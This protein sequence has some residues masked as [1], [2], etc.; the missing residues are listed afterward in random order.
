M[1]LKTGKED[2]LGIQIDYDKEDKL[3][4]FSLATLKDRY[5][6]GDETHAQHAFAR[7][8][9]FG[10]TYQGVTDF[11]FAQRL[12]NYASDNWFM[13]STP[14]LSNGGLERGQPISCFLNYVPDSRGGL[15]DHHD[16]NIWLASAGG[17]IGGYWGDI[18][19][20]GVS[21]SNGSESTGS[22][23][24]M[25]VIDSQ[26]LAYNQGKTRRGS[27][28]AYMDISHP[29]IEEFIAMRKTTGGDL[30]RKCLNLHNGVNITD[31]F[32]QAVKQDQPWRLIDPKTKTAIKTLQARD[33][34]WQLIHT[35]AET[36]EPY[37]VNLDRCNEAMPRPQKDMGLKIRQSNLCSEITLP[38]D[39][40]RTAVCCLSSV[41]LEYFDEWKDDP[42]FVQDLIKMLDNILE[43]FISNTSNVADALEKP[44][45][46]Q[47]F[48]NYVRE[49]ETRD[50]QKEYNGKS[51]AA[52]SAYRE[53]AVGL[54]AM[55]F[56]SYLQRN[57]IPFEGM[58][59]A[60]FNNRCF[61]YIKEQAEQASKLLGESRGEA[62]DM[63]GTGLRNSCLLAVAPNASSSIICGGTSPSIEPIRANVFTHKTLT[64]SFKVK[65][66][67]LELLLD[68]RGI[69]NDKTW[70]SIAAN[71]GSVEHLDELTDEEKE[72]FKTA[73]DINQIWVV[74]HAYQRQN[75]IC[76]SQSVNLFFIPPP[77]TAD[78]EIHDEYLQYV[79][80]VHWTGANKLKSMYYLR[81]NA[82]RNT[83]NVNVKIPRINLEEQECLS[84]EG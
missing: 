16:E 64:G 24:F 79:H 4:E 57:S 10:A 82:A 3:T 63:V 15:S 53:R 78:Q 37:I 41:N 76:Q 71:E 19:S 66:K 13:F 75:Y 43:H 27:Y 69:N 45:T 5:L 83:E 40:E 11:N 70:Q 52:Y 51:K 9:V 60:S 35:R 7:A 77:A 18:R 29:E 81:S 68:Q 14:I 74:E 17:G 30:N 26:M 2:Y 21:T 48:M 31:E 8:S 55:G 28:A 49:G 22:I 38:T 36:G 73:P 61:K 56:H 23:P 33:L 20:N 80:N 54:G 59:A 6:Y 65:N 72:V 58:Y 42:F 32:L 1:I 62:P 12:Y 50:K 47:E 39:E 44:N 84:C 34:W 67:Y 46:L 25:H